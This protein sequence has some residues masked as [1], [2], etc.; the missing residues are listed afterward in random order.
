MV[1]GETDKSTGLVAVSSPDTGNRGL[2][3]LK[4]QRQTKVTDGRKAVLA[5][6]LERPRTTSSRTSEVTC[7]CPPNPEVALGHQKF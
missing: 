7:P 2:N 5:A 4:H 1:R 3:I 6:A